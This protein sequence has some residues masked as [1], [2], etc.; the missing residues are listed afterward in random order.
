MPEKCRVGIGGFDP[1]LVRGYVKT[2]FRALWW[3]TSWEIFQEYDVK[4]GAT[5]SGTLLAVWNHNGEKEAEP[6]EPFEWKTSRE[7][8]Y[9]VLLPPEAI[10]K[11]RLTAWYFLELIIEKVN[12]KEV[13]PGEERVIKWWPQERMGTVH[14]YFL[15]YIEPLD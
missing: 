7:T 9:A 4:P 15:T 13:W 12:G 10:V 1:M 6:N 3:Y 11:Y 5:I 14:K 2:G 8:G